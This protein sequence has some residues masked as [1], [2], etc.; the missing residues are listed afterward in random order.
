MKRLLSFMNSWNM[1]HL[2]KRTCIPL[3]IYQNLQKW[4]GLPNGDVW[5]SIFCFWIWFFRVVLLTGKNLANCDNECLPHWLFIN[6]NLAFVKGTDCNFF[7]S[8]WFDAVCSF[9]SAFM[10]CYNQNKTM[11]SFFHE[12]MKCVHLGDYS[13]VCVF[14]NYYN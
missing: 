6:S 5:N 4:H 3:D 14:H 8:S 12:L 2:F 7:L 9:K 11:I 13:Y 10:Y 1:V